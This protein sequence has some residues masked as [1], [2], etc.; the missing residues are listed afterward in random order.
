MYMIVVLALVAVVGGGAFF[1]MNTSKEAATAPQPTPVAQ[2]ATPETA[3]PTS[4]TSDTA[5][6]VAAA[7]KDGTYTQKGAYTSPAGTESVE[8]S[9]TLAGD[10]VTAA[11][12]KGE[13]TNPGSVKNQ[14]KFATGYTSL[15][16]G[17]K[18]DEISLTVVNGSSLTPVG[19]MDALAKVKTEAKM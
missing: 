17:K 6:V 7:Y 15:V 9:V 11:T 19:F 13:A 8:V 12:F 14:E 3:Q 4:G 5:P 10:V 1:F 18:I 2:E 16:V